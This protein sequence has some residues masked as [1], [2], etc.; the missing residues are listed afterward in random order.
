MKAI[1]WETLI[2]EDGNFSVGCTSVKSVLTSVPA[3]QS[4]AEKALVARLSEIYGEQR[5]AKSGAAF[6]VKI[7]LLK[8]VCTVTLDTSGVGLHKRGYRTESVEAPIK[9][10]LAAALVSLSFWKQ[11][12]V[13]LD[14]F[15][16]SG[17]IAIEAAMIARGIAPGLNRS[18]AA[19]AWDFIPRDVWKREK[20]SAY[21]A[22]DLDADVRIAASDISAKAIKAA[23]ANAEN[24]GVDDCIGFSVNSFSSFKAHTQSG[25]MI[26]NPPYGERIGERKKLAEIYREIGTFFKTNPSWSLFLITSD[27]GFE[28]SAMGRPADRRRKLYNGRIE[29]TY[30]QYHGTKAERRDVLRKKG[31]VSETSDEKKEI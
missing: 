10:T 15:C 22:I 6:D 13:L 7:R 11:G 23:S 8:D 29:T 3:C 17:T 5:F 31:V 4:V 12:R 19:E 20:T 21:S 30:Y 9:E 25:V 26:C 18:F 24:A 16:G 28:Q 2:P 27:K 14:P 1:P